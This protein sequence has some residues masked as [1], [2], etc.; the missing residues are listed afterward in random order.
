MS[1]PLAHRRQ[2]YRRALSGALRQI[3]AALARNP[4]V[5]RAILF[6]SYAGGRRDLFTDLDI[7][8]IMHSS[9]DF[10]TRTA[11]LHRELAVP[12]DLDLLVY[13]PREIETNRHRGIIREALQKGMVIYEK[14]AA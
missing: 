2:E 10:V 3:V 6:G 13:T 14:P 1:E 7:L 11:L 8:V 4:D 12:V 9:L 5:E